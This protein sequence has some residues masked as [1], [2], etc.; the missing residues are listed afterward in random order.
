MVNENNNSTLPSSP[1]SVDLSEAATLPLS[2]R[3]KDIEY[4][5]RMVV[6]KCLML[7]S[8]NVGFIKRTLIS[9]NI[10]MNIQIFLSTVLKYY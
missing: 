8:P 10:S 4:Q 1:S 5:V 9:V 2:I 7:A 3:E 6:S